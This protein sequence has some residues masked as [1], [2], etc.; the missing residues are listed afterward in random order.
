M[1]YVVVAP[2][3]FDVS[4]STTFGNFTFRNHQVVSDKDFPKELF[5]MFPEIFRPIPERKIEP[6]KEVKPEEPKKEDKKQSKKANKKSTKSEKV[7]ENE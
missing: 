5:E 4:L 2:N 7:E 6:K 1:K 3:G